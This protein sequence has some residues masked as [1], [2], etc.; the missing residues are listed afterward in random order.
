MILYNFNLQTYYFLHSTAMQ[1]QYSDSAHNIAEDP[2]AV[3]PSQP[4]QFFNAD[5]PLEDQNDET[6]GEKIIP[7]Q[8]SDN[9]TSLVDTKF[10]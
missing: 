10:D 9:L 7:S 6:D 5:L 1:T 4:S 2:L 8:M 3:D